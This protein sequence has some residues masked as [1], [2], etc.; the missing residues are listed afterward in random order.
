M[1]SCLDP[2]SCQ[3]IPGNR[4]LRGP[5]VMA[6]LLLFLNIEREELFLEPSLFILAYRK[7]LRIN[8]GHRLA[9]F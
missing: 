6:P 7:S 8:T 5:S 4:S 1:P 2:L 9:V 3:L